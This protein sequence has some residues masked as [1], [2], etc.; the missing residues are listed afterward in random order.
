M[1]CEKVDSFLR[2]IYLVLSK[3][4]IH[5][6]VGVLKSYQSLLLSSLLSKQVPSQQENPQLR[7]I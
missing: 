2:V 7:H 6:A 3:Q 5:M 1:S 4:K